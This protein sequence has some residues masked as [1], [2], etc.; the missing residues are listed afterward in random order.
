MYQL[1]NKTAV[2]WAIGTVADGVAFYCI[3]LAEPY[4]LSEISK[5]G[6]GFPF[7]E[8]S[9]VDQ[10]G[11]IFPFASVFGCCV[12]AITGPLFALALAMKNG[13]LSK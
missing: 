8:L 9:T 7:S 5:T 12:A 10:L 1:A 3:L 4:G 6:R 13:A 11:T 2:I